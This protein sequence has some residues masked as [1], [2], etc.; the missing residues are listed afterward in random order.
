MPA[1]ISWPSQQLVTPQPSSLV[2]LKRTINIDPRKRL[3]PQ[4]KSKFFLR[5]ASDAYGSCDSKGFNAHTSQ[6]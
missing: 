6:V 5:S 3:V 1:Q 4:C 2:R